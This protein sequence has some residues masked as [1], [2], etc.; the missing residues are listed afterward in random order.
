MH[1]L[2]AQNCANPFES[3]RAN[4]TAPTAHTQELVH[5][6]VNVHSQLQT[7]FPFFSSHSQG[8]LF[9]RDRTCRSPCD[10]IITPT[11]S[12]KLLGL[13]QLASKSVDVFGP[14]A[15]RVCAC[16]CA[17]RLLSA[18]W[19]GHRAASC[20]RRLQDGLLLRGVRGIV[21]C[22]ARYEHVVVIVATLHYI[23]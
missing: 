11:R 9:L 1:K 20:C 3:Q 4:C 5:N 23:M 22:R 18:P 6:P 15:P 16:R 12:H 7:M 2:Q 17:L 10:A 13:R 14:S 8:F 19:V 21:G